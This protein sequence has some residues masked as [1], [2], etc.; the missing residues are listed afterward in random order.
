VAISKPLYGVL[1]AL[2]AIGVG[3]LLV[4][5]FKK[6]GQEGETE[7]P[8]RWVERVGL[9]VG[10]FGLALLLVTGVTGAAELSLKAATGYVSL[11][12]TPPLLIAA[13]L[14]PRLGIDPMLVLWLVR[15]VFLLLAVGLFAT[16]RVGLF[17]SKVT[18]VF[19]TIAGVFFAAIVIA[20]YI[21]HL[22]LLLAYL[23]VDPIIKWA[24]AGGI[25]L[26]GAGIFFLGRSFVRKGLYR[27]IAWWFGGTMGVAF[28]ILATLAARMPTGR[29]TPFRLRDEVV[30]FSALG[31]GVIFL[32]FVLAAL[33]P[34]ILDR[35]EQRGFTSFVGA[36]HVRA[37]KSG[38]LTVIS[39][40]SMAGVA[41]SSCALCSVTSIMGGFGADLKRKILG[42]NAHIVVDVTRPGGFGDWETK[43]DGVRLSLAP[44]GG[45]ATPVVAGD[46]M[47]SSASNTAG[48][49]VRG[50]DLDTISQVIDL[51]NNI[52]VGRFEYLD[53]P[54]KLI[55][56][57][58]D[59]KIG[60]GPG[61][62]PYYK[63][64]DLK[65][66]PDADPAV[67]DYLKQQ[68]KIYP[69]VIIGRE[70][71]KS[72]HVLVGDEIMLL[73]PIGELGPTGVMPRTRRFRVAG[74]FYSGMYEYDA[75]HAYVKLDVAQSFFSLEDKITNIDIRV[76]DPERVKEIRPALD[77]AVSGME[78][79]AAIP[80]AELRVRDWMEMNRNL[81]SALK[82]EK[83]ATFIIL[84]I[85]IAVASFCIICTLLLMVTEK[86]KEIAILKA[87]GASDKAV[88][89]IFMIEGVIIGGI[90]TV[91]GVGTA[92]AMCTGLAWFG[93]RLDPDVYYIDRLPVNVNASDYAMV[94]V[95]AF[96]ICTI[97]TI[98]PAHAA[99][100]LTPVD[101]LRYE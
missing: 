80:S 34:I 66:S 26:L 18:R 60:I 25:T 87:L 48:A 14:A 92:L 91:F 78:P 10:I 81:F 59:E 68:V 6:L 29:A 7:P 61:G 82:L 79:T 39:V 89:Q 65:W 88:M 31:T 46:A 12:A 93:V 71:A 95:A 54:E 23:A 36:R 42:N 15:G 17:K 100:K 98:Y 47:A 9:G 3:L 86:G 16:L 51:K 101:G 32:L 94:A 52:E 30:R 1:L 69:G 41:V 96:I 53:N 84:S 11:Y 70:L 4:R 38:F 67:R 2:V 44:Q 72:L 19:I 37:T 64:P 97:A 75:T 21:V 90:G 56:L 45:A 49:L 76:P 28:A 22:L 77:Q 62:E 8:R 58:P 27:S 24:L 85:A 20:P 55:E 74:I 99:S 40:L 57:P 63:G 5:G 13:L 35:L 73:S 50:I 43:L 33:L 83:I